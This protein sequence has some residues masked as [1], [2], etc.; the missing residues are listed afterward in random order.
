MEKDPQ[1]VE[2]VL[3]SEA[4]STPAAAKVA[5]GFADED[6]HAGFIS[7]QTPLLK[8]KP[9]THAQPSFQDT[10]SQDPEAINALKL[11]PAVEGEPALNSEAGSTPKAANVAKGYADEQLHAGFISKQTP[12]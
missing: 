11:E 1:H 9:Q 4:G 6:L 2:P 3:R 8:I 10:F 7:K 5:G 12:R